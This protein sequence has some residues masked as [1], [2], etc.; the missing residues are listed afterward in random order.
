MT[1]KDC[2]IFGRKYP[3]KDMFKSATRLRS[4]ELIHF[5]RRD[6]TPGAWSPW[7]HPALFEELCNKSD[8]L[9]ELAKNAE[10]LDEQALNALAAEV[11]RVF[12]KEYLKTI[13]LKFN[14]LVPQLA[15]YFKAKADLKPDLFEQDN[16][17]YL[18]KG[19]YGK[20]SN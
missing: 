20:K 17:I 11:Y 8:T 5:N 9:K 6:I 15:E 12:T 13:I 16:K 1:A 10:T 19:N 14:Q 7:F 3:L 4:L 18:E 2:K